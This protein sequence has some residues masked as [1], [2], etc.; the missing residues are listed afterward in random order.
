MNDVLRGLQIVH[1]YLN[2]ILN[3]KYFYLLLNS[4]K[5]RKSVFM[6]INNNADLRRQKVMRLIDAKIEDA[7]QKFSSRTADHMEDD[8]IEDVAV[9][10]HLTFS[11][12]KRYY[13]NWKSHKGIFAHL[14]KTD[15]C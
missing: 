2:N 4:I 12:L 8:L 6:G 3:R 9:S 1:N 15:H 10:E 13:S 7:K 14:K 5:E 11:T